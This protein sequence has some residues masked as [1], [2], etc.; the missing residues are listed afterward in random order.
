[1]DMVTLFHSVLLPQQMLTSLTQIRYF[2]NRKILS[3]CKAKTDLDLSVL[4]FPKVIA[5]HIWGH[6]VSREKWCNALCR[7]FSS[8]QGFSS[9]VHRRSISS[10]SKILDQMVTFERTVIRLNQ[11][12]PPL[13]HSFTHLPL[14]LF[15]TLKKKDTLEQR[16]QDKGGLVLWEPKTMARS[17]KAMV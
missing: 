14:N 11:N 8:D 5:G 15:Y 2:Q 6:G 4:S 1:M 10:I 17:R 3:L 16:P 7:L 9:R 13:L 12:W